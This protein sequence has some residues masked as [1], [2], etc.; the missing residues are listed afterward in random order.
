MEQINGF[1]EENQF[2]KIFPKKNTILYSTVRPNQEHFGFIKEDK[3]EL[4]VSTGFTTID[5]FGEEID[6]KYL[7]Y[8]KLFLIFYQ[9]KYMIALL[10]KIFFYL[11]QFVHIPV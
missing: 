1:F 8:H 10:Y 7:Y 9:V 3:H 2:S 6:P 4:V 11:F 5:I